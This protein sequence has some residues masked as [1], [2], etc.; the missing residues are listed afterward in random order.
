MVAYRRDPAVLEFHM[1]MPHR[2]MPVWQNGP[3]NF[4]IPGIFRI[5]GIEIKRPAAIR[6]ADGF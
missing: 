3:I 5:G 6:Y 2:F 1:P 4:L